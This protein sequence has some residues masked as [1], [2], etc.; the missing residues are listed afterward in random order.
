[1]DN[2]Q[3]APLAIC[4]FN[5]AAKL[6]K[7]IA[8]L[9][10]NDLAGETDLYVFVDGPRPGN[11][12]DISKVDEV[13]ALAR[14]ATGFKSVTVTTSSANKGLA[15]SIIGAATLLLNQFGRVIMVEDDLYC[16]RSF[17]RYMN[18]MLDKFKDDQRVMQVSG[19]GCKIS[20]PAHY[21][22]D[23][24]LNARAHS[25]TWATWR[26]RWLTV[27]WEVADYDRLAHDRHAIKSFNRYGS[28]LFGM[29]KGWREGRNNS[30][31]IRFNYSMHKQ[32]RYTVCPVKSLVRNDGF[33]GDATNCSNYNR[34]KVDFEH[35]HDGTF[36][37]PQL[38]TDLLPVESI[39]QDAVKYWSIRYRIYGKIVSLLK[40]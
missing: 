26:D 15:Q 13:I 38:C 31:Y 10:D 34:Y 2:P 1:M 19:Y 33:G 8:A 39:M 36:A 5:R 30:W 16:S 12:D 14:K 27:D 23:I 32:G 4:A 17:L 28:D 9:A 24:Y 35:E 21:P 29:L 37:M 3:Y 6:Q 18:L 11:S 25:W 40:K 20:R 22:H 7:T